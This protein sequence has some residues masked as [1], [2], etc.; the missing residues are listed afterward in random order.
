VISKSVNPVTLNAAQISEI[1]LY[2][3]KEAV[4]P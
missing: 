2:P 4:N 3:A 1:E